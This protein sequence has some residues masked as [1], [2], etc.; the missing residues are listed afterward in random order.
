MF[1]FG[2]IGQDVIVGVTRKSGPMV[3]VMPEPLLR[4]KHALGVLPLTFSSVLARLEAVNYTPDDV[5]RMKAKVP[6][7]SKYIQSCVFFRLAWRF[8]TPFA[9]RLRDDFIS[10]SVSI[11][12]QLEVVVAQT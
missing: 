2:G 11:K 8:Q 12:N 7:L 4:Y 3:W 5:A 1:P 9:D 10:F 6:V